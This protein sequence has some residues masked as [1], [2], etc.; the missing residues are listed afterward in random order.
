LSFKFFNWKR[1]SFF[2]IYK[3]FS[4]FLCFAAVRSVVLLLDLLGLAC[5]GR[6]RAVAFTLAGAITGLAVTV[7]VT[8]AVTSTV[9]VA[10]TGAVASLVALL[11][12]GEAA[13]VLET[14]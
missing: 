3:R 14:A 8:V 6:A 5:I 10:S 11:A 4:S 9:A 13:V 1:N 2:F 7:A 12:A